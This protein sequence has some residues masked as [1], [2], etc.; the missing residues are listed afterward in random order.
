L[1]AVF[2]PMKLKPVFEIPVPSG[3][4]TELPVEA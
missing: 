1:A 3:T 2:H 4:V